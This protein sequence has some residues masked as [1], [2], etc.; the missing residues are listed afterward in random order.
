MLKIAFAV[1][2]LLFFAHEAGAQSFQAI[3][4]CRQLVDGA[5]RVA[6]YDALK[7]ADVPQPAPPK[8]E[9]AAATEVQ[10]IEKSC[11]LFTLGKFAGPN[12]CQEGDVAKISGGNGAGD[13]PELVAAYCERCRVDGRERVVLSLGEFHDALDV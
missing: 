10:H 12:N 1:V 6:C 2:P 3:N 11:E 13:L 9:P 5:D 4:N 8:I 7:P